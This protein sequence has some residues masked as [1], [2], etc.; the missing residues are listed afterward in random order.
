MMTPTKLI[1]MKAVLERVPL[2]KS[3]IYRRIKACTFP[4][5]VR[6]GS[7]RV[8]F[9]ETEVNDWIAGRIEA[10]RPAKGGQHG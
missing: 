3:E 9:L 5:Q 10:G 6:L 1:S 4:S 8:A 7:S 2:S